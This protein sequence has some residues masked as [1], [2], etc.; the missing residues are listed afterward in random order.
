MERARGGAGRGMQMPEERR[1]AHETGIAARGRGPRAYC[2]RCPSQCPW[3]A[4]PLVPPVQ[5]EDGFLYIT[6][7]GEN[8]FGAAL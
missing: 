2:V 8:T 5:D 1:A 4:T 3:L 6:Y 7:S